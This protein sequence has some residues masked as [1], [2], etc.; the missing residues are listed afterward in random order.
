MQ[1]G[2]KKLVLV[3]TDWAPFSDKVA[4]IC[5]EEAAKAGVQFEVRKDDWVYLTRYGEVDELGGAD[6]PQVFIESEGRIVHVLTR[7]P[8]DENGKPDFE[9]ARRRIADALSSSPA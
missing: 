1:G 4:K 5:E 8:L 2:S 9:G 6:V 7:V 3:T